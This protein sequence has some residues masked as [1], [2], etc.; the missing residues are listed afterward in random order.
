VA[1]V[2]QRAFAALLLVAWVS[3]ARQVLVLS[4]SR[5][6]LPMRETL[7]RMQAQG[8]GLL[9]A[10]TLF[11]LGAS[12]TA[13]V[14][15][16]C[17]G[18]LLGLLALFGFATR[19]CFLLSAPLY[20]SYAEGCGDFLSFQWDNMLVETTLLASLLPAERPSRLAHLAFRVLLFK[21]YFESGIAKW[22]SHL[23]DWHDGSAMTYYYET[24]PIPTWLAWYAHHLPTWWHHLESRAALVLELVLPWLAWGPRAGRLFAFVSLTG[25]QVV[26]TLTAN[27][28]FFT[29]L[30]CLLH[31]FLLGDRDVARVGA[32]LRARLL[33]WMTPV[34]WVAPAAPV[35]MVTVVAAED[36][37]DPGSD[38]FGG[39]SPG[40]AFEARPGAAW[41]APARRLVSACAGAL[42][43]AYVA[44]S[45]L[46]ALLS[47]ARSPELR[48]KFGDVH[49]LYANLRV[50]NVYHLFGHITRERIEPEFQTLRDGAW[51]THDL[52]YKPGDPRRPP[53]FV[54]P[55]Q[56]RVD[57]RL[58]FYGLAFQRGMPY[59]VDTLLTRM[60]DDPV[61]VQSLFAVALPRRPEAVR[62]AFQRYQFASAEARARDGAWWTREW[63]GALEARECVR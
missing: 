61:A 15:G 43:V 21:L 56:P 23:G 25:F 37:S 62:I 2:F 16:V 7:A 10:P 54:A 38:G 6:L 46:A 34:G 31:L 30:S 36:A 20:L 48:A 28:G 32:W 59:F 49:A 8:V 26:N 40:P 18:A 17:A 50:A 60:C 13:L 53:P 11:W 9:D 45:V 19:V 5:G 3:L 33:R 12:D 41:L 22:Q 44:A 29:Y 55:H 4:G 57:F 63:L 1:L 42:V 39:T 24:A 51:T 47:F 52:R 27:Y 58:W 35:A 14:A